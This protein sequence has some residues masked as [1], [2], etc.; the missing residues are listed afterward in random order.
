MQFRGFY[1]F[2]LQGL[3]VLNWCDSGQG[4][5]ILEFDLIL[6]SK[7]D[8]PEGGGLE[9]TIQT[10]FILSCTGAYQ[11]NHLSIKVCF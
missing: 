2:L 6:D 10:I 1:G 7:E 5:D 4:N 11:L 3:K 8:S 9:S